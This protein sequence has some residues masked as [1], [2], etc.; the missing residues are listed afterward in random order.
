M[1]RMKNLMM[2]K[3]LRKIR[4]GAY[5]ADE[6]RSHGVH[7]GNNCYIGTKHI[8]LAHGFLIFIGDN[9]TIS[10]ARILAHDASTKRAL[11]YSKVGIV[12]I[13][14]NSFIGA[15]AIIL[16][17]VC[18]GKNVIVGAGTVVTRD[19]PDNSV[20]AGNPARFICHTDEYMEKN[21]AKMSKSNIW[22]TDCAEKKDEEKE[23]MVRVLKNIKTGF[24]V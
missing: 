21:R 11:G 4:G 17:G 12:C 19:I 5:S 7:I 18:I 10:N 20:V 1:K 24:D 9:V 22:R 16:P 6:L 8:D 2:K 14:D 13:G 3:I 23:E 15:G